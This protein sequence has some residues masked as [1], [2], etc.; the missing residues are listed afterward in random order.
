MRDA[1]NRRSPRATP[2][3]AGVRLDRFLAG[4][5]ADLSR[6]RIKRLIQDGHVASGGA[7]IT[8]PSYR[9]KPAQAFDVTIPASSEMPLI[10]QSM[11]LTVVHEDADLLVIDKP[12][13]LVVHPGPGR[14]DET[15]VNALLAHC[16]DSLSGIGGVKRPGIVHRLDKDTSGLIV[17]A[18]NDHAHQVLA[19]QFAE[20]S[21]DRN[22]CAVVWG[23]P[24]PPAGEIEGN[25]GRH[26]HHRKKMAVVGDGRGKPALT[27]Y[28]TERGF[29]THAALLRCKLATGR[30]HQIRVHLAHIGHPLIGD[31]V[32]GR[33]GGGR[34]RGLG[35]EA[36]AEV[37]AFSRQALH[38]VVIGFE[39]PVSG[40]RLKF[41]SPLP[42]DMQRL[43]DVLEAI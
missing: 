2:E 20:R 41:S 36:A 14:P 4:A 17:V 1:A 21:I 43:L 5:L 18:K 30:T 12:A 11:D 15:L 34:V 16:G 10:P 29:G 23:L 42:H 3:D 13:G 25:I 32:Y 24:M 26:P 39:H 33:A 27:R 31:P 35:A 8:D 7:T 6:S 9:V 37:G 38:A 40:E 28:A 22:Y 19:R